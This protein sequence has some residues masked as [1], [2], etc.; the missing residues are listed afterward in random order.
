MEQSITLRSGLKMRYNVSG[1]GSPVIIMHGWGCNSSTMALF[2]QVAAEQHKVFNLNMP[3]FG[4]SDEPSEVWGVDDYTRA[5][6]EFVSLCAIDEPVCIIGHSFGGRVGILYSSRHGS[7]VSKLVLVDAAGIKPRRSLKYYVKVYSFK[8]A[9]R[10]S[11]M[12]MGKK[13]AEA[14]IERM[15]ARAGSSDYAS[16]SPMMRRILSRCV[17]E[18]LKGVMPRIKASTLL[19]WGEKDTATPLSDA[20][21]M[22][23]LIPDAGL[24]SYPEAGHFSFLDRP[25]QT[26]A[27]VRSFLNVKE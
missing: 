26:A 8:A 7:A 6:E 19:I 12:I 24:V 16:A 10:L 22:Q 18:D 17:N 3:G 9:R 15:R 2:E 23:R 13:R 27:V 1:E 4:G 20:K 25:A 21:T 5:L 14:L 11:P